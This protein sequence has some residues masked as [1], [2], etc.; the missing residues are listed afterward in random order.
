MFQ[1]TNMRLFQ[2]KYASASKWVFAVFCVAALTSLSFKK[3][4]PSNQ[5]PPNILFLIAD[6]A[7]IDFS[8]YG[9]SYVNTPAFDRVAK[10]GVLFNKAYTPNAKCA[11]SR[12]CIL[13]GRNS[14]QLEAAAN[15]WIYF[16]PQF[17]TFPEVLHE[18]GYEAGYTG[19]GYQPGFA[20]TPDGRKR[21]LLIRSYDTFRLQPPT[22][23]IS[24]ID[25]ASNFKYFQQVRDKNK[26]WFFWI[27]FNEP[28][29]AY[30]YGTGAS[31]GK[32][33]TSNISKVP[34]YFPDTDTIRNDLL[35]YAFEVEYMDKQVEK[36]LE[37]LAATG[38][39]D[40]TIIVYTSDHG[41][42]FPRVKGNQ[43]EHANHIP[44]AV[45]WKNGIKT[46][47]RTI[48]DYISFIDLAPTFL[49]AAGI[50]HRQS[51]MHPFAGNSLFN[52]FNSSKNGQVEAA[53][54][55]VL[56]GQERHDIGRPNDWGYPIRGLH[57]NGMLYLINYEPERWPACNPET[58]YLN[59]DGGATKTF[60]L[61]QRRSGVEKKYWRLCFGHRGSVELYDIKKD[62]D[63]MINLAG[64]PQ[65]KSVEAAMKAEMETKLKAEGDYRMFGYGHIYEQYPGAV[66]NGFYEKFVRGEKLKTGWV[67]STDFETRAIDDY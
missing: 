15:H 8:A 36:I 40:N 32:K 6:D 5:K 52:I 3:N 50:T 25:Y 4:K 54:N 23:E 65:Y 38:E 39:L 45:M 34:G 17:K 42:P 18:N 16:P 48:D 57:K 21:D 43:Y 64:K 46:T 49:Q 14:W 13:T 29:R 66:Y 35:D 12:S 59:T 67:S 37:Y 53:R 44:M 28:H 11:P 10:E 58:G 63:C 62:P 22:K 56:V 9:C 55:F 2:A 47:G 1:D 27:G 30:E 7:G 20:L 26:P 61:N 19:K 31:I 24:R 60:I 41:M 51:G 33:K